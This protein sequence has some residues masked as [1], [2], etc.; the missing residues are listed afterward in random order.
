[1]VGLHLGVLEMR[2][3]EL[4]L[5]SGVDEALWILINYMVD[6]CQSTEDVERSW[7]MVDR[8]VR[9]VAEAR[10]GKKDGECP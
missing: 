10:M 2:T 7:T 9:A 1:V 4:S 6:L 3:E 8:V 5:P